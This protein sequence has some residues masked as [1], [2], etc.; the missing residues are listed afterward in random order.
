M[1]GILTDP[2][3]DAACLGRGLGHFGDKEL[4]AGGMALLGS[5]GLFDRETDN[6]K[7]YRGRL[8][9]FF[10]ANE[11][12]DKVKQSAVFLSV[13]GSATYQLICS[14]VA[15]GNPRIRSSLSSLSWW[16]ILY[17]RHHQALFNASI[18]TLEYKRT[19]KRLCSTGQN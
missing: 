14:L 5:V 13:C 16:K 11:I 3:L 2:W 8:Q 10:M 7:S 1:I 17:R 9:Q 6:W 12:S 15:P 19:P 4:Q 18:S